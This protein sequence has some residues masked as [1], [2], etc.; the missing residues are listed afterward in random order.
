[1]PIPTGIRSLARFSFLA[2]I[3]KGYCRKDELT[4]SNNTRLFEKIEEA[5]FNLCGIFRPI[6]RTAL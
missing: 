5:A 1:M 3:E 4:G 6:V 2:A